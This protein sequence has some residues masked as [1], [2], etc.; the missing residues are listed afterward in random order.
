MFVLVIMAAVAGGATVTVATQEFG[1][2]HA[3]EFAQNVIRVEAKA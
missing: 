1:S 2:K 3:C